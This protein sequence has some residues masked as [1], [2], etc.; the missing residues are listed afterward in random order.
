MSQVTDELRAFTERLGADGYPTAL[1]ERI[2]ERMDAME[3][4]IVSSQELESENNRLRG[5]LK[6]CLNES[7]RA[8]NNQPNIEA[9][10]RAALEG[11]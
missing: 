10:A 2:A 9:I 3:A 1:L 7:I 4:L 8:G 11:E 5:A 6:D